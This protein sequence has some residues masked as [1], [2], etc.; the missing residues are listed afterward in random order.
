[1]TVRAAAPFPG[2][3]SV[4]G[5]VTKT[6]ENTMNRKTPSIIGAAVGILAS[7]LAKKADAATKA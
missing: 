5:P 1:M 2:C 3:S 6:K 4:A 7:A